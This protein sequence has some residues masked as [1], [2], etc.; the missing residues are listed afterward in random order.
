MSNIIFTSFG[1]EIA[2]IKRVQDFAVEC[3]FEF[4]IRNEGIIV[5]FDSTGQRAWF[6][7][8]VA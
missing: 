7:H 5:Y 6:N 3:E 2:N 1:S 8:Q 4:E